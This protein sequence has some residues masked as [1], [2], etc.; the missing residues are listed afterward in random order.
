M[1]T[2]IKI[3]IL[4]FRHLIIYN[5]RGSKLKGFRNEAGWNAV[6][7]AGKIIKRIGPILAINS[8]EPETQHVTKKIN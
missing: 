2:K 5:Y 4:L 7:V 6:Y 8:S 3:L 1:K